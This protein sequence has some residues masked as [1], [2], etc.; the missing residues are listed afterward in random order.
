M[1]APRKK[2]QM[3]WRGNEKPMLL[4]ITPYFKYMPWWYYSRDDRFRE[5]WNRRIWRRGRETILGPPAPPPPASDYL[6][7]EPGIGPDDIVPG[8]DKTW[9]DVVDGFMERGKMPPDDDNPYGIKLTP[10]AKPKD[11]PTFG[12]AKFAE[13]WLKKH[14]QGGKEAPPEAPA[15]ASP[16]PPAT[17]VRVPPKKDAMAELDALIGLDEVKAQVRKVVSVLR[18]NREREKRGLQRATITHH[19]VFTGNPGTG[20]TTVARIVGKIFKEIGLLRSG[21][22]VEAE[23]GDLVAEYEGQ[24]APKTRGVIDAAIDGVLFIDEAYSLA[25]KGSG[26]NFG[27]EA[28]ATLIKGMEDNRD[29]LVVIVAGY[30]SEM[31]ELLNSNPGMKSRFKTFIDFPD[32]DDEALFRIFIHIAGQN[33]VRLSVDAMTAVQALMGDFGVRRKGFGNGRTVRNVFDECFSRM[34]LRLEQGGY[35]SK[36]DLSMMEGA[37]VPRSPARGHS[38]RKGKRR[39]GESRRPVFFTAPPR[40]RRGAGRRRRPGRRWPVPEAPR[41][42]SCPNCAT[43]L[44]RPCSCAGP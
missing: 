21:H 17:P 29:R 37:D 28:I 30:R 15:P 26:S 32:Y 38:I 20:K 33:G 6:P 14:P 16:P 1:L 5:K 27:A 8:M 43:C 2:N 23:R 7:G 18:L 22:V 31:N 10:P 11:D 44:R 19:L 41:R 34:A 39:P 35:G 4:K 36:V 12:F 42:C 40:S 25:E 9:A 24:T 13:E 3:I